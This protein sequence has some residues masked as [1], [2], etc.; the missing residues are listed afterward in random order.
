VSEADDL[1]LSVVRGDALLRA[2]RA[3]GLVPREGLGVGRRALVLALLSWAPIAVWALIFDRALPGAADEP[4]LQHF[5][6]HVRCL[7][8]IPLFVLA[9]SVAHGVTTRLVPHFVHSGLVAEGDRAR[10]REILGGVARLRDATLPWAAMAGLLIAWLV[11]GP[12]PAASHELVWA[13]EPATGGFGFGALW[14]RWVTLPVFLALLLAWLWRL[15][16]VTVLCLRLARLDLA[17]VP[18]H[19]DGAGG[20]GFLERL[21]AAFSP[22]VL[23]IST[24]LASRWA[25]DVVYHG[26]HVQSLRMPMITF[27]VVILVL[28]L[29]PLLPWRRPLAAAKRRAELEYGALVAAHGRLVRR[30]WILGEPVGD[31]P[32]LAAPELGP[33]ADTLALYEATRRM[34]TFPIGRRSL[35][36]VLLPAALP[37]IGVLA[38]EIPVKDLLLQVLKTLA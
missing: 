12:G 16:L 5:G 8:A 23:A 20:L 1:A 21:P 36:A 37:L 38:I 26:V 34:R 14:F 13:G 2:Q 27:G 30:R 17:L 11:L 9:E 33:V 10:F 28:F 6:I 7:V 25:H 31:D 18:T 29:A 15:A 35:L 19:P 32:I 4:L 3:I 24:V 22:V